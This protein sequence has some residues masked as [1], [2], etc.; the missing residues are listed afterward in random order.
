[1]SLSWRFFLF[2]YWRALH[3]FFLTGAP[4]LY[5]RALHL[6]LFWRFF[7][8]F[9]WGALHFFFNWR[10]LPVLATLTFESFLALLT[11]Q[12]FFGKKMPWQQKYHVFF[13]GLS[14]HGFLHFRLY[15][16]CL[17]LLTRTNLYLP[18]RTNLYLRGPHMLHVRTCCVKETYYISKETYYISKETYYTHY[19]ITKETYYTQPA[20]MPHVE[21]KR[22]HL[23]ETYMSLFYF[24]LICLPVFFFLC[25][26]EPIFTCEGRTCCTWSCSCK[27]FA[28][29]L[30]SLCKVCLCCECVADVLLMCCYCVAIANVLLPLRCCCPPCARCACVAN[31]LLMCCY[32]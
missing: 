6:S 1:L 20:H 9:Y 2:F 14:R 25:R 4:Y 30:P 16:Q 3:F 22:R 7:L 31:V 11:F 13:F 26:Q 28:L 5:W 12:T 10:A 29:L 15:L 23:H 27:T 18:T 19:Y 17:Q 32:C 21:L 8:F 24:F